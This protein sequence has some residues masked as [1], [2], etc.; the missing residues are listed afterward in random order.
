MRRKCLFLALAVLAA[1]CGGGGSTP[2]TSNRAPTQQTRD[3]VQKTH[4][5]AI[6]SIGHSG[7][8]LGPRFTP[9]PG[10]HAGEGGPQGLPMLGGF[11]RH[12]APPTMGGPHIGRGDEGGGGGSADPDP[13]P[14]GGDPPP[15]QFDD[16]YFDEWLG[17]WVQVSFADTRFR[18]DFYVDEAKSQPAGFMLSVWPSDWTSYPVAWRTE[19]QFSAGILN[20]S[21]GVYESSMTSETTGSMNYDATWSGDRYHGRSSWDAGTMS[22]ANRVDGADGSWSN[23]SGDYAGDGTSTIRSENSLGYRTQYNWSADGSGNGRLEG[24]DPGLPATLRWDAEGNGTI[25]YADGTT[26]EFSW[27]RMMGGGGVTPPGD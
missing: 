23:D 26:E 1:G 22:W 16:F 8:P 18:Q 7:V 25:T 27:W 14:G 17:L 20:G 10:G 11:I 4:D 6:R 5:F 24:P 3:N 15:P 21:R 9:M 19:Y 12:N 13:G 2:G